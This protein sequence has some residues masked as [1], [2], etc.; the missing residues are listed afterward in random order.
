MNILIVDDRQ[1]I[2]EDIQTEVKNLLPDANCILA[3]ESLTAL[4]DTEDIYIDVALLDIDMPDMDGLTLAEKLTKRQPTVNIVFITGHSEFALESYR[5]YASDFLLKPVSSE[6]LKG[7]FANL[8]HKIPEMTEMSE[9]DHYQGGDLVSKNIE[10]YRIIRGLSRDEL[11][12]KLDVS[13]Q[14]VFRWESGKRVPDLI[15]CVKIAKILEI[16]LSELVAE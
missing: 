11:A 15:F 3:T 16:E 6:K 1:L 9:S 10:K 2:V 7:A 4:K 14:T 13:R 5:V 12:K 8:R